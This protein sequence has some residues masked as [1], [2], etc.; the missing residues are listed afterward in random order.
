MDVGLGFGRISA[1]LLRFVMPH[2]EQGMLDRYFALL[3][4]YT[5]LPLAQLKF[6]RVLFAGLPSYHDGPLQPGFDRIIQVSRRLLH[7]T[8]T[9]VFRTHAKALLAKKRGPGDQSTSQSCCC[10]RSETPAPVPARSRSAALGACCATWG[11]SP[12]AWMQHCS[13]TACQWPASAFC[14]CALRLRVSTSVGAPQAC[15]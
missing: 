1:D 6:K 4:K 10:C 2:V 3:P 5:G 7:C 13:R 11:A 8:R 14:R 15:L 12:R 9:F